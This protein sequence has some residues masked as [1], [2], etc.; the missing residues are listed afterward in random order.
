MIVSYFK[1][2]KK[3]LSQK[4]RYRKKLIFD[5]TVNIVEGSTFEGANKIESYSFFGGKMGYGSYSG[6]HFWFLGEIGRFTSIAHYVHSNP[7]VHPCFAPYVSTSPMFY[8][9]LRQNGYSFTN[10]R[11][12]VE[13]KEPSKIGNDC[14]IGQSV[15]IT[16]NVTIG[17]GAVVLAG[18]V[19]T[20]DV[21]SYAIVGGVPAR[22]IG[23]RYDE[24]TI[25]F[26]LKIKWWNK[27]VCWL[28]QHS[29]L[30]CDI[31]KLK[32]YFETGK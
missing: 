31:E 29:D 15:F 18:A 21:P 19:V 17:D 12:F 32:R 7:F 8:S 5:E 22:I 25:S 2:L 11:R 28:E 20:K 16:G 9:I 23:Y 26:L 4:R 3:Y 27:P 30:L 24:D 1:R 10:K 13:S 14:W 6:Q